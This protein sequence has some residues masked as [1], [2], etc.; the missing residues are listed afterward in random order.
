MDSVAGVLAKLASFDAAAEEASM[1]VKGEARRVVD[2][3]SVMGVG[4]CGR[5][6][7]SVGV[8]PS[9]S[10]L[11]ASHLAGS[12]PVSNA[13]IEGGIEAV[14]AVTSRLEP[15]SL[16]DEFLAVAPHEPPSSSS[17]CAGESRRPTLPPLGD[18][19][20]LWRAPFDASRLLTIAASS[21]RT[22][23]ALPPLCA[24]PRLDTHFTEVRW[25]AATWC[26]IPLTPRRRPCR[27]AWRPTPRAKPRTP[28]RCYVAREPSRTFT[29]ARRLTCR[30]FRVAPSCPRSR[31]RVAR[32]TARP[33]CSTSTS[34]A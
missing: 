10:S 20:L 12:L 11:R 27:C 1:R 21:S 18:S 33:S 22:A 30:S 7:V 16:I 2:G 24:Q 19:S 5:A 15:S 9:A 8:Q 3:V 32:S 26:S 13:V 4:A 6:V 25:R 14:A 31:R 34:R 28:C 23:L 17:S 29:E